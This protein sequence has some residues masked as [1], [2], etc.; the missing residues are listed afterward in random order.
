VTYSRVRPL[1]RARRRHRP[2]LGSMLLGMVIALLLVGIVA[3]NGTSQPNRDATNFMDQQLNSLNRGQPLHLYDYSQDRASFL[4]IYDARAAGK[5]TFSASVPEF[6]G[7]PW[8]TCPSR[9]YPIP[10]TTELTNPER[11]DYSPGGT[12]LVLPQAEPN[13]LFVGQTDGTYMQCVDSDGSLYTVYSEPRVLTFPFAVVW[14]GDH[15]EKANPNDRAS[16]ALPTP[17]VNQ[18]AP[19]NAP[20]PAFPTPRP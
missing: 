14:K 2:H 13:G 19:Q 6:G 18:Q 5:A 16:F 3:C 9:G 11:I 7:S 20:Q 1:Q 4:A 12:A 10:A 8:F 17:P 15:F